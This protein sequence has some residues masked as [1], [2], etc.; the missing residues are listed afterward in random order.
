MKKSLFVICAIALAACGTSKT[1]SNKNA[2]V[3]RGALKFPGYTVAEYSLG[4]KANQTY[5]GGCHAL[6]N[7]QD[8]NEAQWSMIV[9]KM[10]KKANRKAGSDVIDPKTQE[11]IMKYL[12]TMSSAPSTASK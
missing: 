5:C 6:K 4:K 7:P 1:S 11:A 2:D 12:I 10:V 9:P 3:E 8:F